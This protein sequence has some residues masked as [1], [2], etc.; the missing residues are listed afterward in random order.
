ML[1]TRKF[2]A[3]LPIAEGHLYTRYSPAYYEASLLHLSGDILTR[4]IAATNMERC[5]E[6]TFILL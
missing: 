2:E 3:W 5:V 6:T 4:V 1:C